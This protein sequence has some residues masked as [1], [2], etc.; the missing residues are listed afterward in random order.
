ML[1]HHRPVCGYKL[2][3]AGAGLAVIS[4]MN[5]TLDGATLAGIL[6][7][8]ITARPSRLRKLQNN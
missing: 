4:L 2:V 6:Q 3:F 7:G 1:S 8:D 5:V